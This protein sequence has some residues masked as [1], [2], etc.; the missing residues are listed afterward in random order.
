MKY[1]ISKYFE[2]IRNL[3]YLP[4]LIIRTF[5]SLPFNFISRYLAIVTLKIKAKTI[6]EVKAFIFQGDQQE[7]SCNLYAHQHDVIQNY[8]PHKSRFGII[9]RVL[10]LRFATSYM[11]QGT[12]ALMKQDAVET[13]L[14]TQSIFK[15]ISSIF[16]NH[17]YIYIYI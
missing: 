16:I 4:V 7:T 10:S 11:E 14:M 9:T 1:Y 6:Y 12:V 17:I 13:Y 3:Q 15:E 8:F 2:D 5:I